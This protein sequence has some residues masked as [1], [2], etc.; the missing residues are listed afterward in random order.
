MAKIKLILSGSTLIES[1]ISLTIVTICISI[2][3]VIITNIL[4]SS[5][6]NL[7]LEAYLRIQ[8]LAQK[9][10]E[11]NVITDTSFEFNGIKVTRTVNA[12]EMSRNCITITITAT[13]EKGHTIAILHQIRNRKNESSD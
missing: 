4:G 1:L 12:N 6:Q 2:S 11:S 9:S 5:N 3:T 13:D 7:H 10:F 8:N